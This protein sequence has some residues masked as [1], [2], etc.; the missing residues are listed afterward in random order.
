MKKPATIDETGATKKME[1][2]VRP[3]PARIETSAASQGYGKTTSA[4]R[5]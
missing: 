4:K 5:P 3:R 1:P 2:T